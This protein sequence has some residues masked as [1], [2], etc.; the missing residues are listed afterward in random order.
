[1]AGIFVFIPFRSE[2]LTVQKQKTPALSHQGFF[3][4]A[5]GALFSGFQY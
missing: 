3:L 5:E 2:L 4:V 1:M